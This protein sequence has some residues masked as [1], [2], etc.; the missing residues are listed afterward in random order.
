MKILVLFGH[1][2]FEK[3]QVNK[4]LIEGIR[5]IPNVTFHDLYE[6]YPELDIDIDAEQALLKEHDCIV[7][8]HPLYW[9]SSPAIF[10]EWQDL[11]LE[12]GWA[13]GSH[14]KELEGKL[15]FS[16]ITVGA[17]RS[18]Y[19]KRGA[20]GYSIPQFLLPFFRMAELCKMHALP[21]F[22]VHS[23]LIVSAERCSLI[24]QQYHQF[25]HLLA[26]DNVDFKALEGYEYINDYLDKE[27]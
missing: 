4:R 12:H 20:Q 24:S 3:S 18:S 27:V 15:F 14:G 23:T 6:T 22:A 10:K 5:D 7:F 21:P 1:P 2:A 19:T 16:A 17:P 11:V 8:Q 13:Y 26:Q 25:L 9:Y